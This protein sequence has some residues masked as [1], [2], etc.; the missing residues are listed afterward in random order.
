MAI[1]AK[2]DVVVWQKVLDV[3]FVLKELETLFPILAVYLLYLLSDC[4]LGLNLLHEFESH[5]FWDVFY[6]FHLSN[7]VCVLEIKKFNFKL[8]IISS[9]F[10]LD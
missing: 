2:T 10:D 1:L 5:I 3:K 6:T 9:L 7:F 8:I 4:L